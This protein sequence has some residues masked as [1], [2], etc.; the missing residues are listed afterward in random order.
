MKEA[1][2]ETLM[3]KL[4]VYIYCFVFKR[5]FQK[6]SV[7]IVYFLGIDLDSISIFLSRVL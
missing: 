4:F 1:M 3:I 5:L 2:V 6:A 7:L